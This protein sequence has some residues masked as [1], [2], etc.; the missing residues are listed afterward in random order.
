MGDPTVWLSPIQGASTCDYLQKGE[1]RRE[2]REKNTRG[3]ENKRL[4]LD[5]YF[6]VGMFWHNGVVFI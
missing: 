5:L 3:E 4:E 2:K 6:P 1:S